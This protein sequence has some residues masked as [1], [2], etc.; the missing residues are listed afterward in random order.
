M[1]GIIKFRTQI[2]QIERKRII[3]RINKT[4]SWFFEK[5]NMIDKSLARL[6]RGHK[7]S[8]QINKIRNEMEEITETEEIQ[9][10]STQIQILLKRNVF[11]KSGK[12]GCNR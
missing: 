3:Q 12:S 1:S 6:T 2:N 10:N 5:I 9:K 8:I 4:R 11:N 7:N